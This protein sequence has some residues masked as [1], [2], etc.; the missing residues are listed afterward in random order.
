MAIGQALRRPDC[1]AVSTTLGASRGGLLTWRHLAVRHIVCRP[2][3][4]TSEFDLEVTS[5]C[6]DAPVSV[7]WQRDLRGL[8]GQ[9][10]GN[11]RNCSR[12]VNL[13]ATI[14]FAAPGQ[15]RSGWR[16]ARR[17]GPREDRGGS[18]AQS[19]RGGPRLRQINL[20][21]RN[22]RLPTCAT[23]PRHLVCHGCGFVSDGVHPACLDLH[24]SAQSLLCPVV[25]QRRSGAAEEKIAGQRGVS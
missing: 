6:G 12:S 9:C 17:N 1:S 15:V 8:R 2:P 22:H 11:R 24:V 4:T 13:S 23:F 7:K 21:A 25:F 10:R 20:A 14:R 5:D 3:P 19:E 18:G 16:A